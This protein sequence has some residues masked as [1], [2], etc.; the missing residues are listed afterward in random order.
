MTQFVEQTPKRVEVKEGRSSR[1]INSF[2]VLQVQ[3]N[4]NGTVV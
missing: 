4:P 2:M 1:A 3:L